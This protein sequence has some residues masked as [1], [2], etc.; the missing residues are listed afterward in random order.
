MGGHGAWGPSERPRRRAVDSHWVRWHAAYEDPASPLSL[1][2]RCSPG[3]RPRWTR[4]RMPHP[5][6]ADPDGQPVRR[7][8]ARRD[9]RGGDPSQG[10][11]GRGAAGRA[12]PALVAFARDRAAGGRGGRPGPHRRGRCLAVAL[13]R[14]RTCRPRSCWSAACSGTSVAADISPTIQALPGFFAPGGHVI[15]TRHR[16]PP[17][18]T[19]AIRAD[20]AA[21]GFTELA[22]EAPECPSLAVG[23]HRLDG[24]NGALRP[25]PAAVQ[26]RRRRVESGM[27]AGDPG[28]VTAGRAAAAGE[29][30]QRP[31]NLRATA[32]IR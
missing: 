6:G 17:D 9:R 7:P 28:A 13:V 21:A 16:R 4:S 1:R 18:G 3:R 31:A 27:T 11:G 10:R 2:L 15:W 20:F 19:P 24:C 8:G 32:C 12:D 30:S 23:H 25:R 5:S 14:R 29:A 26:L 22:F